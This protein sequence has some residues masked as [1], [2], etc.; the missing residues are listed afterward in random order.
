MIRTLWQIWKNVDNDEGA[1]IPANSEQHEILKFDTDGRPMRLVHEYYVDGA[2]DD[3]ESI[4]RA[5]Q[6]SKKWQFNEGTWP[7]G[8]EEKS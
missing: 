2:V 7:P 5:F 1:T 3:H 8:C 4:S 6:Y